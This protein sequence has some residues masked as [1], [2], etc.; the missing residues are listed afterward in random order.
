MQGPAN[1]TLFSNNNQNNI[2]DSNGR[3]ME[4]ISNSWG[5]QYCHW[6]IWE[7]K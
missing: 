3:I 4:A 1:N 6:G 2:G 5:P 7:D